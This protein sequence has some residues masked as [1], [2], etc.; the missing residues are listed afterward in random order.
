M[1][2][3]RPSI[4]I[5]IVVA[6]VALFATL[7]ALSLLRLYPWIEAVRLLGIS[8]D[9]LLARHE[10]Y[11][12]LTAT[13]MHGGVVHLLFNML[14]LWMLGP[15]VERML[16]TGRYLVFSVWCA[17]CGWAG[18]LALEGGSGALGLGYSGVIFGI[19]VAQAMFYPDRR[20]YTY[21][22]FPMKM[23]HAALVLGAIEVYLAVSGGQGG[24]A[25]GAHIFGGLGAGLYL[26]GRR[27]WPRVFGRGAG[28][29]LPWGH[30][31]RRPRL[32][33]DWRDQ[34]VAVRA[35]PVIEAARALQH[36]RA[37]DAESML[38]AARGGLATAVKQVAETAV[39]LGADG[40]TQE[41][42]AELGERLCQA[43]D[44][45]LAARVPSVLPGLAS[46]AS[47]WGLREMSSR[48]VS[49][50]GNE[51]LWASDASVR[52]DLAGALGRMDDDGM[53][54]L[55]D[56]LGRMREEAP[57]RRWL[58]EAL[59]NVGPGAHAR[60]LVARY[61]RTDVRERSRLS[62]PLAQLL[63][64]SP[65]VFMEM[66]AGLLQHLPPDLTLVR[67]LQTQVGADRV[68]AEARKWA[69]ARHQASQIVLLRLY[70]YT[71]SSFPT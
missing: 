66:L 68:E 23:K 56:R 21:G 53:I 3:Q 15:D 25:H 70:D 7:Q 5:L 63:D 28:A 36:G 50:F 16:G 20:I 17:A 14:T 26:L 1:R 12:L 48:V 30:E 39:R 59:A 62:Q 65:K 27:R 57:A 42:T 71:A 41:E 67:A 19:L 22:F 31:P 10:Y 38:A 61:A 6:C 44:A 69:V 64:T 54:E 34:R 47:D 29:P 60:A 13:L 11:R 46:V 9:D 37:A 43:W 8:S 51:L 33:D 49:A 45:A 40:A 58:L 4:S 32:P 52:A 2:G 24:I 55:L 18:F 35:S